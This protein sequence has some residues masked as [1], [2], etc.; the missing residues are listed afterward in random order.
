MFAYMR[1]MDMQWLVLICLANIFN[2][3]VT[4]NM[5]DEM[6]FGNLAALEVV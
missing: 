1:D 2:T 5:S 3:S 6:K 4:R